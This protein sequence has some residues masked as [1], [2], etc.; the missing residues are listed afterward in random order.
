MNCE[1]CTV[2]GGRRPGPT[3]GVGS[4]PCPDVGKCPET[5]GE[6]KI[7]C[8]EVGGGRSPCTADVGGVG[9]SPCPE[10]CLDLCPD[11]STEGC[12]DENWCDICPDDWPESCP[13]LEDEE[14]R[15]GGGNCVPSP[16][17]EY[18]PGA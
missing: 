2:G 11:T 18:C 6:G 3:G 7:P 12:L 8:P 14:T 10:V 13:E 9:S 16:E 1:G 4:I 17:V 15:V 5:G